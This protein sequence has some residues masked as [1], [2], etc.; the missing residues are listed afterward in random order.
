MIMYA[1]DTSIIVD[2]LNGKLSVMAQFHNAAKNKAPMV[3]PSVVDY[4]TMRGFYHT[5]SSR[6]EANY[7]RMRHNC[8]VI[9][10]NADIW[11]CA[12]SI[13]AKLRKSGRSVGDADI[14]IAAC[15]ILN[16]YTLVTHNA[17][18]FKHIEELQMVD[19]A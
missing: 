11:D 2:Y 6:K 8:P 3:I 4:E 9:E 14:L 10:V 17:K 7:S 1:L 19:W 13:W 18:D 12:A 16:G 5:P 15:C